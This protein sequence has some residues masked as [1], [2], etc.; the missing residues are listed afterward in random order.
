[1]ALYLIQFFDPESPFKHFSACVSECKLI[2]DSLSPDQV[3]F[4]SQFLKLLK[5]VTLDFHNILI[6]LLIDMFFLLSSVNPNGQ[7]FP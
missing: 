6:T 7:P 4:N 3:Y 1:M 2:L 5:I